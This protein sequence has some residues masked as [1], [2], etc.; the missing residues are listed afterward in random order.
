V[1]NRERWEARNAQRANQ[2]RAQQQPGFQHSYYSSFT[3]CSPS[4]SLTRKPHCSPLIF[5]GS[6][7]DCRASAPVRCSVSLREV[8][9][10]GNVVECVV[11]YALEHVKGITILVALLPMLRAEDLQLTAFNTFAGTQDHQG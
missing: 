7:K 3:R 2:S 10:V 1:A 11:A 5:S 6:Q 4:L 8:I 9:A